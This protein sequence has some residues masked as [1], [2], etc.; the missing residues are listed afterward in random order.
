MFT[1]RYIASILV[2][3]FLIFNL[4]WA[5]GDSLTPKSEDQFNEKM[6]ALV[7][8]LNNTALLE[9]NRDKPIRVTFQTDDI[10]KNIMDLLVEKSKNITND[11][12]LNA[13]SESFVGF[14]KKQFLGLDEST[15]KALAEFYLN[16]LKNLRSLQAIS[17]ESNRSDYYHSRDFLLGLGV[18]IVILGII[19][20]VLIL[21][22]E[23]LQLLCLLGL[24]LADALALY[25]NHSVFNAAQPREKL[26][27]KYVDNIIKKL[28]SVYNENIEIVSAES[29]LEN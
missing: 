24:L 8:E 6:E 22:I 13:L 20:C 1:K 4:K 14:M 16:K 23:G 18:V 3:L 28:D 2:P 26:F 5:F 10:F 19:L 29:P 12:D 11:E 15:R 21:G 25:I 17:N 27:I 9:T 7:T